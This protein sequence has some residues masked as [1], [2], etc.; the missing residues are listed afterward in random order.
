MLLIILLSIS[1]LS[2]MS[3]VFLYLWQYRQILV[4][5]VA[6]TSIKVSGPDRVRES[7]Y[8][9]LRFFLK[10]SLLWRKL[11]MQYL[12]HLLVRFAYYLDRIT[13]YIYSHSRNTF[14]KEVVKNKSSV[15]FFWDYLKVY[16]Q[17]ID[18]EKE[19]KDV[20]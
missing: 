2:V 14:M 3:L 11:F 19:E 9:I 4:G 10:R 16:K 5:E 12:L 17:E 7:L 6:L 1:L 20:K 8:S 13:A 18:Q 15:S